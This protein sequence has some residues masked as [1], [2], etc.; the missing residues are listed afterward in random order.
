MAYSVNNTTIEKRLEDVEESVEKIQAELELMRS[1]AKMVISQTQLGFTNRLYGRAGLGLILPRRW[2]ASQ[3]SDSGL[4]LNL[5]VGQYFGKHNVGD[6]AFEWDLYPSLTVRYRFEFHPENPRFTIGPV[7]GY[8]IRIA[9]SGP[10]DN[11][12][13][14]SDLLKSSYLLFGGMFGFPLANALLTVELIYLYND[15]TFLMANTGIHM[16]F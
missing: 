8:K 3:N 13:S 4:G 5:G 14:N 9:S 16:F 10:W 6:I 11:F 1:Q 7:I 15:Q 12:L 2:S